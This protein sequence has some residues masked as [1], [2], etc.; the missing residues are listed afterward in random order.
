MTLAAAA[1]GRLDRFRCEQLNPH[2][3]CFVPKS[4][5]AYTC[6]NGAF[7]GSDR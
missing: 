5:G 7:I 1:S 3:R 4:A 6:P 2:R